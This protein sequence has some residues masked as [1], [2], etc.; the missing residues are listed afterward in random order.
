MQALYQNA[1]D[2]YSVGVVVGYGL[3]LDN[4]S[5]PVPQVRRTVQVRFEDTD[6]DTRGMARV[7]TLFL[8]DRYLT[9]GIRYGAMVSAL[10]PHNPMYSY[11]TVG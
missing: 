3:C 11:R 10:K 9:L 8:S 4:W 7:E 5:G 1:D 6:A 2:S